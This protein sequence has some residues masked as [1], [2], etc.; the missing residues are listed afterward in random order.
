MQS[1]S[2]PPPLKEDAVPSSPS[3]HVARVSLKSVFEH[4]N[5]SALPASSPLPVKEEN[6]SPVSTTSPS[7]VTSIRP[8]QV[9]DI[10][11]PARTVDLLREVDKLYEDFCGIVELLS[12]PNNVS[13]QVLSSSPPPFQ[14]VVV[15]TSCSTSDNPL[16][17][18]AMMHQRTQQWQ[19]R[20]GS[21][22]RGI[23]SKIEQTARFAIVQ[24][25]KKEISERHQAITKIESVLQSVKCQGCV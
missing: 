5:S 24:Q 10:S 12:H 1:S 17:V 7:S 14:G 6:P 8:V 20:V 21:L 19:A 25:L 13:T 11:T 18:V 23:R 9:F 22:Q 16:P 3:Q 4:R 2:N 15:D